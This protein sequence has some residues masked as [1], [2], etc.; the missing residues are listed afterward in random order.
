VEQNLDEVRREIERTRIALGEKISRLEHKI[1][2][3][4]NTTLNP[5]Y[6]VRT[7][8][9]PTLGTTLAAG[10]VLARM[11]KARSSSSAPE[12][13]FRAKPRA[14]GTIGPATA[15]VVSMVAVN[16]LRDYFNE[17]RKRRSES[18]LR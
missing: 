6:H 3:T 10:F 8:P 9:W 16:F 13:G 12:N 17:R 14:R 1:Q 11:L 15:N 7:R 2:T 18:D 4:K 5:A